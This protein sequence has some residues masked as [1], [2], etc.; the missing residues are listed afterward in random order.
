MWDKWLSWKVNVKIIIII[1]II[2]DIN[3]Y[4]WSEYRTYE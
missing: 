4:I 1:I 3:I 2:I